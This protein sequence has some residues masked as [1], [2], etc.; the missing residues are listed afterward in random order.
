MATLTAA[1][2]MNSSLRATMGFL[3]SRR[4]ALGYDVP[5]RWRSECKTT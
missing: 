5:R 2:L 4:V 1:G 3:L